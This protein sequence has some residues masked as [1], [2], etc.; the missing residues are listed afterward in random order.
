MAIVR[1]PAGPTRLDKMKIAL[2]RQQLRGRNMLER[3]RV[4][5]RIDHK[6][7][8]VAVVV[9][10]SQKRGDQFQQ[11]LAGISPATN[12]IHDLKYQ[13]SDARRLRRATQI[14]FVLSIRDG[15]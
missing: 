5:R 9:R 2:M 12:P 15:R 13:D 3:D 10:R 14:G 8:A 1:L 7:I 11:D 4:V 6:D